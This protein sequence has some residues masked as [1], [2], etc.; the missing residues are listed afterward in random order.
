M[1]ARDQI[2]IAGAGIAGL[3]AAIAFAQRGFSIKIYEQAAEL[4]EAGAGL[5]LSPNATRLLDGLGVLELLRPAAVRP[6]RVDLRDARS[7]TRI[8]SVALGD[9]AESR[10]GAPYLVAHRADLQGA[11]VARAAREPGIELIKGARVTSVRQG[12]GG[13]AATIEFGD[14]TDEV[15]C[16][17]LVGADG[18]RSVVRRLGDAEARHRPSGHVAWRT[19][20]GG[21]SSTRAALSHLMP[22]DAVTV[23]LHPAYHLVAY[24]V[25]SGTAL[26]LVA[27]TRLDK[28][29]E[30]AA[31]GAD[32]A[33]L[34]HAM[35]GSAAP[36]TRLAGDAAPWTLWPLN[37]VDGQAPWTREHVAL[38]GDAA[39]AM[40]PFAAQGAAMGIEDAVTLARLVA[41][42][43]GD[44]GA[45][46][47]DY[48]AIRRPRVK[49]VA[50][51]GRFNHFVWHAPW[52][53]SF[54]RDLVLRLRGGSL[55]AD[56]DWLY[57]YDAARAAE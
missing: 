33:P 40:T 15:A 55:A 24:P 11:L 31:G 26:N 50:A 18:V 51:R 27:I 52:P 13:A 41:N 17:L 5:Q 10:W 22:G 45:A 47:R 42:G 34:A 56:F 30:D 20:V 35:R 37:V 23:F 53:I 48:E 44:I 54:G 28:A 3:T 29:V 6:E 36:L 2:V 9:D 4:E 46:L 39:H 32:P 49:R 16:R 57:G 38:V 19:T 43:L 7:G 14:R 12:S 21:E 25:R 8:A 1:V